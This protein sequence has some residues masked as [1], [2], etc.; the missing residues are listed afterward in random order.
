MCN[1]KK[2]SEA[3]YNRVGRRNLENCFPRE[4]IQRFPPGAVKADCCLACREPLTHD[5]MYPS[6]KTP[7]YMHERCYEAIALSGPK[8]SCLTC[9]QA[10]PRDQIIAQIDNPRELKYA[11]HPGLCKDYHATLAG[12]I[13]GVP[14]KTNTVPSLPQYGS[15]GMIPWDSL[16]FGR[17]QIGN[18]VDVEP[19]K[20]FRQVKHLR[21]PD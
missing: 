4:F 12:I 18:V 8:Q 2:D 14:F 17:Q 3:L 19:V 20:P 10:L 5:E 1:Y 9:G 11:L 16:S 21:L 6:G 7:R 13:F 15:R